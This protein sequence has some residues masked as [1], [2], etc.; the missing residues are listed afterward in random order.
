MKSVLLRRLRSSGAYGVVIESD[1]IS[2]ALATRAGIAIKP[3]KYATTLFTDT[4]GTVAASAAGDIIAVAIDDSRGLTPGPEL[5]ANG[6]F[7]TNTTSWTLSAGTATVTA[8]QVSIAGATTRF[9]YQSFA[10]V[11]GKV[12]KVS[13][14]IITSGATFNAIRKSDNALASTNVVTI[15]STTG[16][17]AGFF[18]ATATT[19]FIVLQ[20]NDAG[21]AVFDNIGVSLMPYNL[22]RQDT[23]ANGPI[24]TRW[25]KNGKRNLLTATATLSTQSKTVTAAQHTLSFKGT[26]TVTLTGV[27]TAGPLIGTGVSDTVSLT[28]TPT[29]GSLTMTVSG[30]VTEAQLELGAARTTYQAV[31]NAYDITE[32]GQADCWGLTFDGTN[33]S[34]ATA[35]TLDLSG[36]DK[37][38]IFFGVSKSADGTTRF[39]A[40]HGTGAGNGVF[41]AA[42]SVSGG[43]SRYGFMSKGTIEAYPTSS[44]GAY[45]AGSNNVTT[46]V[47]NISADN[48]VLRVDGSAI[49]TAVTDQGTGNFSN[50]TNYIGARAGTSLFFNGILWGSAIVS[51]LTTAD[52]TT[53]AAI[54]SQISDNTPGVTL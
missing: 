11:V 36:S 6:T 50:L 54:E 13:G 35:A 3:W 45:P 24:L 2:D 41:Y 43:A 30:S 32:T 19:T 17:H 9:F 33:D 34:M 31:T 16:T 53:I 48:A 7:D 37:L 21:T 46:G 51:T 42:S 4:A 38:G 23:L 28:F 27:S 29:A 14:Q 5:L 8:G 49:N 47:F 40:E 18:A 20:V 15:G 39:M 26:G 44:V 25:P 52:A 12:Y 1:A 10:T 22:Y